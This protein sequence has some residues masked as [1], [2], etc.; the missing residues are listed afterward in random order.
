MCCVN[1]PE[2]EICG[3]EFLQHKQKSDDMAIYS[4]A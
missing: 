1:L 2:P 4:I 3:Y